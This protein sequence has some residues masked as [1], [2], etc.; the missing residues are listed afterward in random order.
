LKTLLYY[1]KRKE[2]SGIYQLR[3]FFLA[4]VVSAG[5]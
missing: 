1:R 4:M 2:S 3:A 5:T